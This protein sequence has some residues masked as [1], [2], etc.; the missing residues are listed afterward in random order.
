MMIRTDQQNVLIFNV[1]WFV[2]IFVPVIFQYMWYGVAGAVV[3]AKTPRILS[4]Q[5][6]PPE[7]SLRHSQ[8]SIET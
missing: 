8:A 4:P 2:L 3:S 5:T 7:D 1:Y 6:P